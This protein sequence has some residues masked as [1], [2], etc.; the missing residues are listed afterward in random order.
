MTVLVGVVVVVIELETG[1]RANN[2]GPELWT[3]RRQ[4]LPES[5]LRDKWIF[6]AHYLL[7]LEIQKFAAAIAL[8]ELLICEN[9]KLLK[10]SE[11]W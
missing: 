4:R 1:K 10:L 9:Q 8:E 5:G 11:S 6:M 2:F 7:A 3:R